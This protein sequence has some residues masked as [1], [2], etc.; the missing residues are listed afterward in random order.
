[1]QPLNLLRDVKEKLDDKI[2]TRKGSRVMH[3]KYKLFIFLLLSVFI[4]FCHAN[5]QAGISD[6]VDYLEIAQNEDGA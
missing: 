3:K 5:S 1:M 6:A 2:Y 4:C